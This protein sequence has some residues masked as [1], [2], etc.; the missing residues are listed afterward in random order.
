MPT[1]QTG[2][3]GQQEQPGTGKI[4][5]WGAAVLPDQTAAVTGLSSLILSPTTTLQGLGIPAFC[6]AVT[7][8]NQTANINSLTF[9]NVPSSGLYLVNCAVIVTS[10]TLVANT[11][12]PTLTWWSAPT[13]GPGIGLAVSSTGSNTQSYPVGTVGQAQWLVNAAAGTSA[14]SAMQISLTNTSGTSVGYTL[15]LSVLRLS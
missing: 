6:T 7:L 14:S 10:A 2:I 1:Q 3:L 15:N 8:A 12:V 4:V 9:W 13:G 11:M 5:Q